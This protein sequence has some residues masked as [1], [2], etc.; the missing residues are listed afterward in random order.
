MI[1]Q[2]HSS[3]QSGALNPV[4]DWSGK[5]HRVLAA[6]VCVPAFSNAAA[7][8]MG[9]LTVLGY[10]PFELFLLPILTLAGLF[11]LVLNQTSRGRAALV[12]FCFGLG[13]FGAG[14]SWIYVSLH[15]YGGM[16]VPLAAIATIGFCGFLALFSALFGA[17]V[18]FCRDSSGLLRVLALSACWVVFEWLRG[19]MFTGFPWLAVGYS[20]TPDSPLAGYAPL[21]GVYGVS[22]L[23]AASAGLLLECATHHKARKRWGIV[24]L[25]GIWTV[26][27]GLQH[28][29]WT[30][31]AGPS[32][33][34]G[35]A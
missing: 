4:D 7:L 11:S 26:G 23:L 19:V 15:V 29:Q 17:V 16:S 33:C 14:V 13:L 25:F 2:N 22:L 1:H 3:G 35:R 34:A 32:A 18:W 28:V 20:Q 6:I 5:L 8:M 27:E 21:F 12:A 31:P 9:A 30:I 24:L 10:A